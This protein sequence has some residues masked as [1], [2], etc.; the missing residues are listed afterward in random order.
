MCFFFSLLNMNLLMITAWYL[1]YAIRL[2]LLCCETITGLHGGTLT[3]SLTWKLSPKKIKYLGVKQEENKKNYFW[4]LIFFSLLNF[5]FEI[6]Y[7]N[8]YEEENRHCFLYCYTGFIDLIRR[9]FQYKQAVF[10]IHVYSYLQT[11]T[12]SLTHFRGWT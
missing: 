1:L 9:N 7:Y 4:S 3:H 8:D 12:T 2:Y 6:H 5:S 10:Q 11:L